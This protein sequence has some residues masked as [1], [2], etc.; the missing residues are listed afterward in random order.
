MTVYVVSRIKTIS[1]I[2]PR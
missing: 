1:T 2:K